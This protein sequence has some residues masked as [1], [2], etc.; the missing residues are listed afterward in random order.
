MNYETLQELY[1]HSIKTYAERPLFSMLERESLT[2]SEFDARVEQVRGLLLGAGLNGGDKVA[3]LSS[4]MPNWNVC[5]FAAVTSGMVAVPIMPDFSA[6]EIERLLAHSE[7]RALMIS[8][9]QYSRVPKSVLEGMNIVIRTKNLSVLNRTVFE[10]G[11]PSIPHPD[12]PAAL[13]YTS[14]TTSSPKGVLLSHRNLTTQTRMNYELFPVRAED[15]FLSV[16]PLSHTYECSIGMLLPF[17]SGASVVYADRMPTASNLLPVLAQI[18]PTIMLVVPLIIEKIYKNQILARFTASKFKNYFYSKPFFRK[19]IHRFAGRRLYKLFGGRLRFFGIGGTRLDSETERFLLEGKFPYAIG[20]GLTETAPLIAGAIPGKVRI[21]ST[22]VLLPGIEGRLENMNDAGE[23]ELSVKSPCTMLGY[24]KNPELTAAVITAD[25]WFHTHDICRFDADGY[26]Y[27]K[28]RAG[29]MI[30][31]PNGENIYP[32]D[33]ESV[34]NSHF[35]VTDSLVTED[36]G[37]LIALVKFNRSELEKRYHNLKDDL[38]AT[39]ETIKSDIIKYVNSKVNK[40]SRIAHIHEQHQDFEKTPSQKIKR[41]LY[42][43]KNKPQNK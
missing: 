37:K 30:L 18:R 23:G 4:N 24:Y 41:H 31:G 11:T 15:I 19:R 1:A 5:Y 40:F 3:I 12:D 32:E 38:A 16:L 8:D 9:R 39:M 27:V 33:I 42:T 20:Y 21:G 7:A 28:G 2:Y 34:I 26:L 36:S 29:S 14:G 22:G 35:L 10:T 6:E 25:G 17:M 13:I 43:N